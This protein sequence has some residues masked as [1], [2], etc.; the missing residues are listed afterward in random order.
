[1]KLSKGK[2]EASS[3]QLVYMTL[4]K[5]LRYAP[6]A[7]DLISKISTSS[8]TGQSNTTYLRTVSRRET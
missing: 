4:D 5:A 8:G 7:V 6:N 1:M 2:D 3:K